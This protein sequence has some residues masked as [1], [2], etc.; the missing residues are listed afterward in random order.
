VLTKK[1]QY[2]YGDSQGDIHREILRYSE[3]NGHFADHF[4]D[5]ICSCGSSAFRLS[6]DENEGAAVRECAQCALQH[7]IGDSGEYLKNASLEECGC[8]CGNDNLEISV[9]VSLYANSDDV[10]WLYLGCRCP[11]CKLTAVYGDWKSEFSGYLL[12]LQRV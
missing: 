5:A 1:G 6:L 12:L 4:S 7:P 10:R 2:W 9:G 3:L 8:P 11:Q